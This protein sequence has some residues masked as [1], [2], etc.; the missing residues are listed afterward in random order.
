[1]NGLLLRHHPLLRAQSKI[2]TFTQALSQMKYFPERRTLSNPPCLCQK[3]S[4]GLLQSAFVRNLTGETY[5]QY[6]L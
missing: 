2:R 3:P 1:M 6:G 5:L 4:A